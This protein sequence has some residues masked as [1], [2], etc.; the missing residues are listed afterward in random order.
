MKNIAIT[1]LAHPVC[2]LE[3]SRNLSRQNRLFNFLFE[4]IQ[5]EGCEMQRMEGKYKW[6]TLKK[7]ENEQ[8]LTGDL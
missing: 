1:S 3:G 8:K 5:N 6:Y 7:S 4:N 2:A